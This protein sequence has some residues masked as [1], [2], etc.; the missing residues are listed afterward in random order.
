[1]RGSLRNEVEEYQGKETAD[2][3]FGQELT[4]GKMGVHQI[5][6]GDARLLWVPMRTMSVKGTD[7]F[8]WVSC[9]TLLRDCALRGCLKSQARRLSRS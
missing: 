3:L 5:W 9:P 6:F 4:D 7:V 1:M 8:T 2:R